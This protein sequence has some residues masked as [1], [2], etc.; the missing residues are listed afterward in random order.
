MTQYL[1]QLSLAKLL[2]ASLLLGIALGALYD[3]FRIRRLAFTRLAGMEHPAE[4]RKRLIAIADRLLLHTEDLLFGLTVGISTVLLYFAL[5]MG[6]VR[7]MALLG[8]GIGFLLYRLTL[9]RLVMAS[10]DLI[11]RLIASVIELIVRYLILPPLR[12]LRRLANALIGKIARRIGRWREKRMRAAAQRETE[13]YKRQLLAMAAVGFDAQA[14]HN[15]I[16]RS[17]KHRSR[18]NKESNKKVD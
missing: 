3:L 6:Q 7:L 9:G 15:Q 2:A 13:R 11:L 14:L 1:S 4:W 5:S 16:R 8:E 12:L 17:G 18:K 10:A